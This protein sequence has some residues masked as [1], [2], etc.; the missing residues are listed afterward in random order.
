[1][2]LE[3][4]YF[5]LGQVVAGG[6]VKLGQKFTP[7][8]VVEILGRDGLLGPAEPLYDLVV[9]GLEVSLLAGIVELDDL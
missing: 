2:F 4:L 6:I 3:N 1:M 8:I 9:E 5:T 7:L